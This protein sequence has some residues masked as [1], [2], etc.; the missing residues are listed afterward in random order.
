MG[1]F[2]ARRRLAGSALFRFCRHRILCLHFRNHNTLKTPSWFR[3]C[4]HRIL[5]LYFRNHE[6]G[7]RRHGFPFCTQPARAC[8]LG[9]TQAGIAPVRS[10]RA[11]WRPRFEGGVR[12]GRG[13]QCTAPLERPSQCAR[14]GRAPPGRARGLRSARGRRPPG[15]LPKRPTLGQA[16]C[17]TGAMPDPMGSQTAH[18]R[19]YCVP[20][21]TRAGKDL[22]HG[23]GGS[24]GRLSPR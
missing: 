5:C 8:G 20:N 7:L 3:E 10:G 16:V 9:T 24:F 23:P 14:P 17:D 6:G 11:H 2:H 4:R 21:G 19:L 13:R 22:S 1:G 12:T 18:A 15:T